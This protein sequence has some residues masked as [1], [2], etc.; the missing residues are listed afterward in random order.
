MNTITDSLI[1]KFG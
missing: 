1:I